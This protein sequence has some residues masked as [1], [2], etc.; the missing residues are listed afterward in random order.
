MGV[1]WVYKTKLNK[2][3]GVDKYKARFIAKRYKQEFGVD[4]K[5]VFA[6]V[7]KLDIIRLVLSMA[8][9]HSWSIHQLDV[10]S[11]FLH[12]ELEEEVFVEQSPGDVKQGCDNQVCRLKK[13]LYGLK[14][15]PR[16]WYSRIDA[17]F[18]KGD[19]IKCSYVH[20][21]Y[22]RYGVDK[23]ILIVCLYL[24]ISFILVM[25]KSCLLILKSL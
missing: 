5:E 2:D 9:E 12:G 18:I 14:Q 22:S 3:G 13:A 10:K 11:A 6:P 8:I 17:Y 4:Y 16:A 25:I 1:K 7:A 20:N 15:A 21:L 19:F 24:I 23:K